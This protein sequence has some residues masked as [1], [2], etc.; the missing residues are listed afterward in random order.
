MRHCHGGTGSR[1]SFRGC[2]YPDRS[3][4][5]ASSS[6]SWL[7]TN[8]YACLL[9]FLMQTC[10]LSAWN[11]FLK[12]W[13]I[14]ASTCLKRPSPRRWGLVSPRFPAGR[15]GASPALHWMQRVCWRWRVK[16]ALAPIKPQRGTPNHPERIRRE[17]SERLFRHR[18]CIRGLAAA[19]LA[20]CGVLGSRALPL[21]ATGAALSTR[22]E[23]GRHD[24]FS[25][26][27]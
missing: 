4:T 2:H 26:V 1:P 8:E 22:P 27:A 14:C 19:G 11:R 5:A 23:L 9:A 3:W 12:L 15:R 6:V 24:P 13:Q 25:G 21:C 7:C 10:I 16:C 20:G 17:V 18:G